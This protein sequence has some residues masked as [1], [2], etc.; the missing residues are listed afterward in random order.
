[1]RMLRHRDKMTCPRSYNSSVEG[2]RPAFLLAPVVPTSFISFL[3]CSEPS[4]NTSGTTGTL[5][6]DWLLGFFRNSHRGSLVTLDKDCPVGYNG[7][8]SI[9]TLPNWSEGLVGFRAGA[10]IGVVMSEWW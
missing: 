10:E 1:M 4:L 5:K 8:S 3:L 6:T 2:P 9:S 7:S